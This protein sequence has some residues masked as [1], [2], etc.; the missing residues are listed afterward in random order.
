MNFTDIKKI[1]DSKYGPPQDKDKPK[2]DVSGYQ[3]ALKLFLDNAKPVDVAIKLQLSYEEVRKIYLQFLSLNRMYKLKQMYYEIGNY[4]KPFLS[5]YQKM[6]ENMFTVEELI[7]AAN[8]VG[9]L[10]ELEKR[11]TTLSSDIQKLQ[12]EIQKTKTNGSR[13]RTN[14]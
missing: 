12:S 9:S 1:V 6:R 10:S 2:G 13:Q 7:E 4:M 8:Y 3:Q 14:A 5:L 11:Y